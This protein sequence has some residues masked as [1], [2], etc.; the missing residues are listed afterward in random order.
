MMERGRHSV[1]DDAE[2]QRRNRCA[3]AEDRCA[4]AEEPLRHTKT[5]CAN[6]GFEAL[7]RRAGFSAVF[8]HLKLYF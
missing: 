3:T 6:G 2:P 1:E 5:R 7:A 8:G 4:T